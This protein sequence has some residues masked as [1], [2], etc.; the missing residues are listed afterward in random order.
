MPPK[1]AKK[2]GGGNKKDDSDE[3]VLRAFEQQAA[4]AGA[5]K[6]SKTVQQQHQKEVVLTVAERKAKILEEKRQQEA[7]KAKQFEQEAIE[8]RKLRLQQEQFRNLMQMMQMQQSPILSA[9]KTDVT[10]ELH[11]AS[12]NGVVKA[13]CVAEAQGWR[14]SMEDAHFV[15]P[16]FHDDMALVAIFDGHAGD[17]CAKMCATLLPIQL[18]QQLLA[19]KQ[20]LDTASIPKFLDEAFPLAYRELDSK[21]QHNKHI[22]VDSGC[23]AV[24]VAVTKTHVICASVGDSRAVVGT[25]NGV[26]VALAIDH[27]PEN[28]KERERIEKAGGHVA[29]NRVNGNLAMSRALGDFGYKTNEKLS[30]EEQLVIA[31]PSVMTHQRS[32]GDEF[33]AVACDGVF[34]VLSNEQLVQMIHTLL[35][36][37]KNL[38]EIS[39]MVVSRCISPPHP[40]RPGYPAFGAGTDNVSLIIVMLK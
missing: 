1:N 13:S 21:I 17:K 6:S 11:A 16:D 10:K 25:A 35:Q 24:T 2:K 31:V 40:N 27:K 15:L 37:G 20:A 3:D 14:R 29:D 8:T 22:S 4:A 28:P 18:T 34:D 19:S 38:Q 26:A 36:D 30:P 23:T 33:V 7:E 12:K 9:P 5:A 32:A 39:E